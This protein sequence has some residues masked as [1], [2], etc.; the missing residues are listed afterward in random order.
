MRRLSLAPVVKEGFSLLPD[1]GGEADTE[2]QVRFLGTAD[3]DAT[4]PLEIF[5]R[6]LHG[7][8]SRSRMRTVVF[9]VSQLGFMNSSCFKCFVSWIDLV[10]KLPLET[11]YEV[12]FVSN[13][14]LQW[15]RRSLEALHRF[16][17]DVVS[18]DAA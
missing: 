14:Q 2:I 1:Q 7:E 13:A 10:V 16:A 18:L 15:Q 3:M 4:S 17:P 9:D 11:R 6:R 5:L 8:A 12:H